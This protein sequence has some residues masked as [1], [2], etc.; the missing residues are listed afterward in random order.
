MW[1]RFSALTFYTDMLHQTRGQPVASQWSPTQ[2]CPDRTTPPSPM[3]HSSQRTRGR[4]SSQLAWGKTKVVRTRSGAQTPRS[5][6]AAVGTPKLQRSS[7][8]MAAVDRRSHL[9]Q[10]DASEVPLEALRPVAHDE[11]LHGGACDR[12][13]A[14]GQEQ[15]RL[16][17]PR[18][19]LDPYPSRREI[20][21]IVGLLVGKANSVLPVHRVHRI[22]RQSVHE[23][24]VGTNLAGTCDVHPSGPHSSGHEL[25]HGTR[26]E[27]VADTEKPDGNVKDRLECESLTLKVPT[28]E[29]TWKTEGRFFGGSAATGCPLSKIFTSLCL[30]KTCSVYMVPFG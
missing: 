23:E 13:L 26:L 28:S 8:L 5:P 6:S 12:E 10:V 7:T 9:V 21:A 29:L 2:H 18:H 19:S 20:S 25:S 22:G 1:I 17:V 16:A 27:R 11:L 15:R 30:G 14:T 24:C 4:C 3:P